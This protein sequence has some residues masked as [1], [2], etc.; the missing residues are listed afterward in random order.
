MSDV[1]GEGSMAN[2]LWSR[3]NV[4]IAAHSLTQQLCIVTQ[5]KTWVQKQLADAL[6]QIFFDVLQMKSSTSKLSEWT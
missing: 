4:P 2:L 3:D 1:K 5:K 6:G